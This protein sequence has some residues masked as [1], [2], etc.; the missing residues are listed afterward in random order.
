MKDPTMGESKEKGMPILRRTV[1]PPG[2]RKIIAQ[3][4]RGYGMMKC[5]VIDIYGLPR[6]V[7]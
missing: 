1:Q 3:N 6:D 2:P 4:V 7:E 5:C